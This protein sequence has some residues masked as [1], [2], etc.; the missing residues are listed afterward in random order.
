MSDALVRRMEWVPYSSG[1]RP[2]AVTH[3][4]TSLA[5]CRVL[6]WPSG[7]TRLGNAKS[8]TVPPR[9][10]SQASKLALASGAISNWTGRPVFCCTTLDL[11]RIVGPATR[12]PIL[13]L[14]RS[15]PRSLLSIARS[16]SARSL[17][18]PS[19]SRKKR[20]D[21]ICL[22]FKARLA[23][24][25]LPAF[26]AGRLRQRDHTVRYPLHFSIGQSGLERNNYGNV[27]GGGCRPHSGRSISKHR[28]SKA[29]LDLLLAY[30]RLRAFSP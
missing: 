29:A 15:H 8:S 19:R 7:W 23:P 20:I 2:M 10:S 25:C 17:I 11:V 18:R 27:R 22:T 3:S 5:Y 9:L 21:Q 14:T 16:K 4:S 28:F 24:I 13:I 12:V 6:R 30:R 1:V 26:Q